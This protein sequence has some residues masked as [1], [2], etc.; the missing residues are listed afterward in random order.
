MINS[1]ENQAPLEGLSALKNLN[2]D[3]VEQGVEAT[4]SGSEAEQPHSTLPEPREKKIDA[5]GRAYS[6]GKRKS[7]IARVWIKPGKGIITVNGRL[8]KD[9]FASA[10]REMIIAQPFTATKTT[11]T[12]DVNCT[13]KGGGLSGQAG[14]VRHGIA[15]AL[16]AFD[17]ELRPMMKPLDL[18]TRD[19]RIVERKKFGR[20]KA[21]R[22]FQFSKR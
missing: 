6:T 17:P 8:A 7:A 21:R 19:A 2:I 18:L 16:Q 13:V 15:R 4:E 14:A 10:V 1:E 9:Y 20:R 3:S 11:G 12:F 22:S 5:Q